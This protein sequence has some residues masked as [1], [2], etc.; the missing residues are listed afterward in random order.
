MPS[1]FAL[2]DRHFKRRDRHTKLGIGDDGALL[3]SRPGHELVVSTDMLVAGTHFHPDTDPS[4]I[5]WKTLAVNLSDLAAMGAE[6]RWA[7]LA[8]SLPEADEPW[9]GEFARGFF[10]CAERHGVDLAGGDTTRGP[11]NFCVTV[12]GEVPDGMALRRSGAQPGDDIWISGRPGLAALGLAHLQ[13]RCALSGEIHSECLAALHRPQP[14]VDLGSS[15]RGIAH[16]AI[17]VSDGLL[18]DLGHI[19]TASSCAAELHAQLLPM[20]DGAGALDPELVRDCLL[21]GGDDFELLIVAPASARSEIT[22]IGQSHRLALTLIGSCKAAGQCTLKLLDQ[23]G[24]EIPV[25]RR[26]YDHF[27][28]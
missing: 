2:I 17:D 12:V 9:I 22:R 1:E 20:P 11:M 18:A 10:E 15:L 6:P 8:L 7:F 14:R 24:M 28:G 21:A 4:D 26:G 13:G 5:G 16:A 23:Q 3:Q 25:A 19:L 27:S